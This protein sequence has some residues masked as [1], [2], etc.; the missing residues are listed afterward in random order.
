MGN[1]YIT[2]PLPNGSKKEEMGSK[3]E[4]FQNVEK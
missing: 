3:T 1:K 2:K 4:V